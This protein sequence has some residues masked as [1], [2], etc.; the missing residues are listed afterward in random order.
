ML[1][2]YFTFLHPGHGLVWFYPVNERMFMIKQDTKTI[3][4]NML[5]KALW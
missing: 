3:I 2:N 1:L 5:R 4:N